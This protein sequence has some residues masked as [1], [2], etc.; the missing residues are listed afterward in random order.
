MK[1]FVTGSQTDGQTDVVKRIGVLLLLFVS[2][3]Q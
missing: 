3:A 2:D 1:T